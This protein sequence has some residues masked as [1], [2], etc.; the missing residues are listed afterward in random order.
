MR[1]TGQTI[2]TLPS[3]YPGSTTSRPAFLSWKDNKSVSDPNAV[4][5]FFS[6]LLVGSG[7]VKM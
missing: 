7:I 6:E 1:T 3:A 5:I 4:I 2:A